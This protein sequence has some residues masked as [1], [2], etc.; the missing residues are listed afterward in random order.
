[1]Y[2]DLRHLSCLVI[3]SFL[4]L[5]LHAQNK[6]TFSGD[7]HGM[8]LEQF[9]ESIES[10]SEYRFYFKPNETDS[11]V[12]DFSVQDQT[13]PVI[14]NMALAH[15][16][17]HFA[18]DDDNNVFITEKF[19]I[20]PNLPDDYFN[21]KRPLSDSARESAFS[22]DNYLDNQK[23]QKLR[24]A[25]ENR[26]FVIGPKTNTYRNGKGTVAGYIRDAKT[27]ETLVGATVSLDN[28]PVGVSTDQFG[29]FSLTIPLGP[30]VLHISSIGMKETVRHIA[31]YSDGKLNIEMEQF[32][33]GL[34]AV[35]IT[36]E[37]NSNTGRLQMGVDR[38]NIK[39]IRQMP[40][41][42]GEADILRAV[43]TLPGVT[44]VG[45]ASTG[46]NVRG[47]S[48]DQNL[49]LFN[50]STIY[51]PSHFFGFFSSFNPDVVKGVELYKSSIP[52]KFGGRL[53]SVLDVTTRDGNSKKI[54]GAGGIG[55]LDARLTIEG[56]LFSEKTTF[57][58]ASR[59]T[60]SD[61]LLKQ[62]PNDAYQNS[63][64]GFFDANLRLTHE[65]NAKNHLFLTG[66][67]SGDRFTL[68][69]DTLYKYQNKNVNLQ[70][71][72]E[73][74]N[75]FNAVFMGGI[76]DY[77][78]SITS[79]LNP[80]NAYKLS[81]KITQYVFHGDFTYN[82]NSV[83]TLDFGVSSIY[84]KLY[85]GS[86]DPQGSKSLVVP[87]HVPTEQALESAAYLGDRINLG[88]K[89]SV[90]LGIRY[91]YYNYLGPQNIY[92]YAPG[93]PLE[94]TSIIDSTYYGPGK[95]IKTYQYPD[96]RVSARYILND[97]S[98]LKI[99]YNSL[100]QFIHQLTNTTAISPTDIWKLSGPHIQPQG[101]QQLSLG[102]YHDF[103]SHTIETSLEIYYKKINDYLDY[104]S[105][106]SL[107]LNHH[108]ETDVLTTRGKAY[109][110]ELLIKKTSGKLNGWL[111]Y[112]YSRTFLQ[113]DDPN[114]GQLINNGAYYPA[115]YD[116]PSVLNFIGNYQLNHRFSVSLNVNYSTGRP[117]TLPTAIY[118]LGGGERVYYSD[119]NAYR[120]PDYF[121]MDLS[122]NIEGNHKIKKFKHSSW[123]IGVYNLTGQNNP[124]SIYFTSENGVI[125]GYKLSIFG[126]PV[127]SITYNFKF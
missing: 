3:G 91:S 115:N 5:F 87:D 105:G 7:F 53:S 77:N 125:K 29:Y 106:A 54:S 44:S 17:F 89:F 70:W 30:H 124:Y 121:R 46:F 101:G 37:K 33:P 113:Q 94:T 81:F 120:I 27:G 16:D 63:T 31:L 80:I 92:T 119:R 82:I 2:Y 19:T 38:L 4:C 6:K 68:N 118:D 104:K 23:N 123:S 122:V 83:H 50:N 71:K 74:N 59:S 9:A 103:K 57:L 25:L 60:Y 58:V 96:Y 97:N 66:Y 64:A 13:L 22:V 127:P 111:S 116:R 62:I 69:S 39:T 75:R 110:A 34:K 28:P 47:G 42:F 85:P 76:D 1:M 35:T 117:I 55:P 98:S 84:Y 114:A 65:I 45:E 126:S 40:V 48:A 11:I 20:Q 100:H 88:T 99:S 73:F 112:T 24:S 78:Y 51:N 52:E 67:I 93:Q 43:L 41:V 61:W 107:V 14:L 36:S 8:K 15:T 56:P 90:N 72:H 86:L 108:I 18:I 109:G 21:V 26:V 95:N 10:Q 79:T 12:L 102:Y 32:I 49:V